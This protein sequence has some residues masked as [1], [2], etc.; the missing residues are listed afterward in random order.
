M[1]AAKL[2][3]RVFLIAGALT[4]FLQLD[5]V[6]GELRNLYRGCCDWFA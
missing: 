2:A 3:L 1:A 4:E 5:L 6:V